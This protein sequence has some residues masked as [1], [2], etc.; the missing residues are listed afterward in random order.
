MKTLVWHY[1]GILQAGAHDL[2]QRR[3]GARGYILDRDYE[4]VEIRLY[5]DNASSVGEVVVDIN[6]DDVSIFKD[7]R[8]SIESY[9][10]NPQVDRGTRSKVQK[11]FYD[12]GKPKLAKGSVITLDVDQTAPGARSLTV[13]LDLEDYK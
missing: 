8:S 6:D 10:A 11:H 3:G 2:R 9:T 1:A 12:L 4:P 13:E 5:L 7:V